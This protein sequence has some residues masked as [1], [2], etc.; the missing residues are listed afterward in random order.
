MHRTNERSEDLALCEADRKLY[1]EALA[2]PCYTA[3]RRRIFRQLIQSL[4]FEQV[5]GWT[6]GSGDQEGNWTIEGVSADQKPAIYTFQAERRIHNFGRIQLGKHPVMR[7]CGEVAGE[8]DSLA[9]FL[10]EIAPIIEADPGRLSHFAIELEQTLINDTVAQY[11]RHQEKQDLHGLAFE[12][13]ESGVMDGHPYHPSYKSRI[14]FDIAD[15]L[16]YGPEFAAPIRLLWVALHRKAARTSHSSRYAVPGTAQWNQARLGESAFARFVEKL[17]KAGVSPD[18]YIMLPVHPWQWR[19]TITSALAA[20]IQRRTLIMLG[21]S[22]DRYTAQQSIRTLANRTA[23][24]E[25]NVKLSLS[26]LNTSTSRVL[27]PHTVENAPIISDW[28]AGIVR[29]DAYLRDE[30]NV[31]VLAEIAGV[32]YDSSHLPELLQSR[33]YGTLSCIWRESLHERLA[34]GESAVPYNAL[35]A[36]DTEGE[37]LIALWIKRFGLAHWLDELLKASISPIIHF[38]YGY[39]IALESHA[40]NMM[41]IHR[42]GLPVRVALKDFH[43]GIRFAE[44]GLASPA[45]LPKLHHTPEYHQRVNRNSFLVTTDL[46]AVRDFVHDAFFFINLG[47]LALFL[48]EHFNFEEQTF[49]QMV[50]QLINRYQ[51]RFPEHSLRYSQ[52]QLFDTKIGVEKLT[53]RRLYPDTELQIHSVENP[54]AAEYTIQVV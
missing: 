40:Q 23:V 27:A 33:A 21:S 9:L 15:Q 10:A 31:I 28:L 19:E 49:W 51:E 48:R 11:K 12:E 3:V 5:I 8:A 17:Q 4:L 1:E 35:C 18:D 54:L 44:A 25:P 16:L 45:D 41:L 36:V 13:W 43:D 24:S 14:G 20:D 26:I 2:S 29:E 22:E 39:G 53:A 46:D 32:A 30:C 6:E 42:D 50:R 38:L 47:E 52:F 37:P 7:E 34:T